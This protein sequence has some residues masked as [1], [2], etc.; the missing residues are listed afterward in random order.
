MNRAG[1]PGIVLA[2]LMVLTIL[3]LA[4]CT[5]IIKDFPEPNQF[6]IAP[7]RIPGE[8]GSHDTGKGVLI[9]QFDISPEFESSFFIYKV[10]DNRFTGDYYNKFMVSPAR[11]ITDAVKEAIYSSVFFRPAPAS[12][13][14][15]INYRLWGKI[16]SLYA[17]ARDPKNPRAVM[18][19]RLTLE[20]Q[21]GTG[22]VPKINQVYA[23]SQSTAPARPAA[24]VQAWNRC[25]EQIL[26]DFFRDVETLE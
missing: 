18:A 4:G 24:L 14:S 7:P 3:C 21:T 15:A 12:A 13:P 17:D 25:L 8:A 10:S 22:F 11:M 26:T 19:V 6:A 1:I 16:I 23:V 20:Q 5:G 2:G 9:R